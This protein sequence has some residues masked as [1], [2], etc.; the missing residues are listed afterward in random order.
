MILPRAYAVLELARPFLEIVAEIKK[1]IIR[2]EQ[3]EGK[4]PT[5]QEFLEEIEEELIRLAPADFLLR[6][7][8][9][10]LA[11][12]P[13]YLKALAVRL[14]RGIS[15]L[16]KDRKRSAEIRRYTEKL[17]SI[18]KEQVDPKLLEEFRWMIEEY[19]VSLFAQELKTAFPIS[20]KRLKEKLAEI[21][22]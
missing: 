1:A 18:E 14:E 2:T 6:Y 13:R 8:E 10:R 22:M 3:R 21:E 7:E 19:R 17:A 11:H 16:E 15:N 4:T 9:S 12:L 20:P 5:I